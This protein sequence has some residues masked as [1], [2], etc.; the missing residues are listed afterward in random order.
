MNHRSPQ[1]AITQLLQAVVQFNTAR[2]RPTA[3]RIHGAIDDGMAAVVTDSDQVT[4]G[5][6]AMST[7]ERIALGRPDRARADLEAL[8]NHLHRATN[9]LNLCRDILTRWPEE[10][11][12]NDAEVRV[13]NADCGACGRHTS[14]AAGDRLRTIH[15]PDRDEQPRPIPCCPACYQSWRR[16]AGDRLEAAEPVTPETWAQW[17]TTR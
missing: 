11:P 14:G 15:A 7:T 13:L 16:L 1:P 8:I 4:G 9:A 10:M 17:R 5:G 3:T 2:P 6:R 12:R